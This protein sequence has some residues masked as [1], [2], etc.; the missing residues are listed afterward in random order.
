[1][2]LSCDF[3]IASDKARFGQAFVNIGL[4]PDT[5]GMWS[6]SRAVGVMRAKELAMTGRLIGA[7]EAEKYGMVP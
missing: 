1:M 5:G 2:A 7:E 3:V 6:L 4:V